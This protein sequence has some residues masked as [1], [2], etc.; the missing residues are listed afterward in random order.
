MQMRKCTPMNK[1]LPA[2]MVVKLTNNLSRVFFVVTWRVVTKTAL[3]ERSFDLEDP[4]L[5]EVKST[6]LNVKLVR[7]TSPDWSSNIKLSGEHV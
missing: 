6:W 5:I 3:S 4:I 2:R 7:Q 1:D